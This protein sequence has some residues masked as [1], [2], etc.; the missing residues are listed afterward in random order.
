MKYIFQFIIKKPILVMVFIAA[1]FLSAASGLKSFKLDASSDALVIEG[2]EAFKIYRETGEIFGSSDFLIITFT[3]DSDLFSP[4]SLATI[5]SLD[6]QLEKLP[7][8]QSVLTILDAPIFFQPK[9]PLVDLMD[10][11]KTLESEDI[12]FAAAKKEIIN[13]PVYSELI[14]NPSGDTTAMQVTLEENSLYRNLIRKRYEL[15]AFNN[16]SSTQ[17]NELTN[18]NKQISKINDDEAKQRANLIAQIRYLLKQNTANGTLFL[19]GASMIATDM[20]GFIKSDLLIFGAGV[21]IVFCL[22]LYLFFQNI[23][24][25]LLPLGNAFL[26]TVFTASVLGLMDW[27]ISVI[28][29]NFIA[30]LLI[31]TISLTVHVLVRFIEVSR[32]SE[33]VDDAIYHTLNQMVI[34]CLFAAL[35]T[36]IAFLSL[37]MGDIKPVIEFGKMMSVGMIFAFFFTFTFLPSAMKLAIKSTNIHSLAFINKIPSRL[38]WLAI[39]KGKKIAVFFLFVSISLIYGISKLEVENRFIDYF[40]PDTEI[41]QGMLLLDQE[42]GGTATLDILIDQPPE[43]IFDDSNFDGD[44]LFEDDLFEDD[45]SDASG[46]WWNAT[47]LSRLEEIHDYLDE[48]PEMGKVLSVASGIKLARMINDGN[49]LNDLELALLRSVL[50]ED[51]KDTLLYSYINQDDSKVRISAR[52][53]ESAQTL[54]RKELLEKINF[55]LVNKFDLDEEQFQ[56]TGLAVLYNNMLQSLFSSQIKSLGLVFAVIGLMILVLFRSVKITLIALTPNLITAGSVLGLLGILSIPLDIMTITVAAIS[57]GMAVD[58]TIHYLYRYKTEVDNKDLINDQRILNSHNSVGRAVFYTAT[59]ISAGFSIFALS[60]FT[61]TILFGL[62]TA[63]ALM[64]SFFASLTLL[65][66]LLS[67]FNAFSIQ[68]S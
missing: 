4:Q 65:P 64:V 9:V 37:V 16:L 57:V 34:P 20:M 27:K 15:L 62:F 5:K 18:I 41:Y 19:G 3:P 60:S 66:F 59:T 38:G 25:V 2:D 1:I 22:M 28:S 47:S 45:S 68:E 54:N 42:L 12:D 7:G 32:N 11:L 48:I 26:T 30:L 31:L 14:I 39:N 13:N 17:K 29:S 21:A 23:W 55:D 35:T 46:Y 36:A 33:L 6:T 44:D 58:N 63:F 8:V 67:F 56:V 49:D 24:F 51:I 40:S 61:P 10:N 52:V 43:V 50:P 53:L